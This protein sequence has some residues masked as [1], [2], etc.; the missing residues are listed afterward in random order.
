MGGIG[1]G[2]RTVVCAALCAGLWSCR[3]DG[4]D[5]CQRGTAGCACLDG[6]L[7]CLAEGLFCNEANLC[8]A[9]DCATPGAGCACGSGGRCDAE[10]TCE[11]GVCERCEDGK[12][13]CACTEAR[14]CAAGLVCLNGLCVREP[15]EALPRPADP[16]CYTPC[17]QS[18]VTTG[19]TTRVCSPEGLL[20]GCLEGLDCVA[21]TCVAA[22]RRENGGEEGA[23]GACTAD[24][25]CPDFA[26]CLKG[27]CMPNCERDGD[28][29]QGLACSRK[30]CRF[31]CTTSDPSSCPAGH[32]CTSQQGEAGVCLPLVDAP[33]GSS[34][35]SGTFRVSPTRLELSNVTARQSFVIKNDSR[36]ALEFVVHR[37]AERRPGK[38][39]GAEAVA[40]GQAL[41]WLPV[42]RVR[43]CSRASLGEPLRVLV[44]G[45]G[46]TVEIE[47]C[48]AGRSEQPSWTGALEVSSSQLGT[49][50][51]D[52]AYAERPDGQWMGTM[53]YLGAFETDGLAS[54]VAAGR[55]DG[56]ALQGVRNAFVRRFGEL[57]YG[58]L[59]W[60]E[61]LAVLQAT[62]S[63]SWQWPSVREICASKAPQGACYL[64]DVKDRVVTYTSSQATV[65]VPSGV[66]EVP[67]AMNIRAAAAATAA[68]G[69]H[70]R[71]RARAAARR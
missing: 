32:S 58:R 24:A 23:P 54:W 39:G 43:Q 15:S 67:F 19:G 31:R 47:V 13:G 21:G 37:K 44:E 51:V 2:V 64:Y 10:L 68:P 70:R 33:A 3:T 50:T 56:A 11:G 53:V 7:P 20:A 6:D 52:L 5:D 40:E 28:C 65:P 69:A 55:A 49:R 71:R 16:Q 9:S 48:E 17:N 18:V 22:G 61:F 63:G 57:K 46:G 36:Q 45:N 29:P 14:S 60:R 59:S 25:D 30:V 41:S 38:D 8:A 27:A 34:G 26:A 42:D 62:R 12:R 66:V 4:P 1:N 35:V